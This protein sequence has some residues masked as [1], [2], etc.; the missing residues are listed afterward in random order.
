MCT[1]LAIFVHWLE[2]MINIS[3]LAIAV[4]TAF[5]LR[6]NSEQINCKLKFSS[7]T[8]SNSDWETGQR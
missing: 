3:W 5:E 6:I 1:N 7:M 4:E 2:Q 8:F